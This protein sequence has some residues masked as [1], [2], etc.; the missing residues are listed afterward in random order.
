[1]CVG[2]A[3]AAGADEQ[4]GRVWREV[5][6]AQGGEQRLAIQRLRDG[7]TLCA[8]RCRRF[9]RAEVGVGV[10]RLPVQVAGGDGVGID[11]SEV[12]NASGGKPGRAV[13]AAK[14]PAPKMM[15]RARASAA[16]AAGVMPA[17]LS[18]REKSGVCCVSIWLEVIGI[19]VFNAI[20]VGI[21]G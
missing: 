7:L 12:A 16:C 14:P 2:R 18:W 1:M 21:I 20:P 17:T 8:V 5:V 13:V 15:M 10:G 3:L 4:Y 11:D 6:R 19:R 9:C